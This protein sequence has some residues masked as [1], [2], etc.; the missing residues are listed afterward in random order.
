MG[1][2]GAVDAERAAV[3][4]DPDDTADPLGDGQGRH[5]GLPCT[6]A[7]ARADREPEDHGPPE[8]LHVPGELAMPRG[9]PDR[10]VYGLPGGHWLSD[11]PFP[12]VC[13]GHVAAHA[14]HG[15]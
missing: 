5:P 11:R 2:M 14:I 15:P 9:S 13:G 6:G 4:P 7:A 1:D 8:Y 3:R 10:V 12:G